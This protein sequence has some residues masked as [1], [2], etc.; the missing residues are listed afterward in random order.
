MY[1]AHTNSLQAHT[2]SNQQFQISSVLDLMSISLQ[3]Y[4]K[5][6]SKLKFGE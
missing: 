5:I 1:K 2:K 4:T 6:P 3:T